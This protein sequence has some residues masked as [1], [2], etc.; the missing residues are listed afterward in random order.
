MNDKQEIALLLIENNKLMCAMLAALAE[1]TRD[2]A[3][4]AMTKVFIE[5]N[6]NTV[7]KITK[8]ESR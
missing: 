5:S 4:I 1:Y 8:V 7:D 3:I 2:D 6:V